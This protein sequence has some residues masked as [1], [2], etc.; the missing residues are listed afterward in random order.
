LPSLSAESCCAYSVRT[1]GVPLA[2]VPFVQVR[3]EFPRRLTQVGFT[4]DVVPVK[5]RSGLVAA[6]RHRHSLWHPG[7]D[8][9]PDSGSA[10]VME[11]PS[12]LSGFLIPGPKTCLKARRLPVSAEVSDPFA[13][14][15]RWRRKTGPFWRVRRDQ[16]CGY[17]MAADKHVE[18]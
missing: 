7:A 8:Q 3:V 4:D 11:E 9:I 15:C 5:N 16:W 13:V 1:F 17:A 2:F 18:R 14:F 6:D 12:R 10:E